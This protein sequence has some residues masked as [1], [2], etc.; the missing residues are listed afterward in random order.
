MSQLKN[1]YDILGVNFDASTFD[2]ENAYQKLAA[3]WHPDKHKTDRILAERKFHDISEAY[4]VLSDRNK[5]AHYNDMLKLEFSLEDANKTFEQFF[6]QHGIMDE[7][8]EKFFTQHYPEQTKNYYR[9]LGVPKNASIDEIK[10]AYRKISIKYHPK[11][12]PN[13]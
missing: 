3:Q 2:I 6:G 11:N 9:I 13:N 4:D 8:E 10:D 12:N 5:R 1:Y 7:E